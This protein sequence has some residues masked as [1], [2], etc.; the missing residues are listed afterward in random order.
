MDGIKKC[1]IVLVNWIDTKGVDDWQAVEEAAKVEPVRCV[2]VG[3]LLKKTRWHVIICISLTSDGS[4]G[5]TWAIHRKCI[6]S[7]KEL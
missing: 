5:G 2:S 1:P 3:H 4:A 6:E 7:L